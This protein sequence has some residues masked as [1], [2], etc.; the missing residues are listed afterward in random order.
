[1]TTALHDAVG[2]HCNR[3]GDRPAGR[4]EGATAIRGVVVSG[5]RGGQG[6]STVAAAM[7]MFAA[8]HRRTRL[9]TG[10]IDAM[11]GVLG[12]SVSS[13]EE[14]VAVTDR[15]DLAS[16]PG[17]EAFSVVDAGRHRSVVGPQERA[18]S[19]VVLRGPC[20]LAVRDLVRADRALPDGIVLAKEPG[21]SLTAEDVSD[22]TG[23]PVVAQIDVTPAVARTLDAGLLIARL[24]HLPELAQ[25]RAWTTRLLASRRPPAATRSTDPLT[26]VNERHRLST[27]A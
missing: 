12:L 26:A 21:R 24:H 7:A 15:L 8:G 13:T 16:Q 20:Y 18:I 17:T 10:E 5:A 3:M 25:L 9:I 6:T 22:V 23:V 14:A 1:M 19:I 11:A 27:C 2:A 4:V